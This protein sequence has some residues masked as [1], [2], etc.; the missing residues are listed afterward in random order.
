MTLNHGQRAPIFLVGFMGCG[1]SAVGRELAVLCG[2]SFFDLDDE[3]VR[4]AGQSISDLIGSRGEAEFRQ[5][6][7]VCL[8][9][10]AS[11]QD[12][13]VATGGGV[14]LD[15][16]NRELMHASGVTVWLDAPFGL[17]WERIEIDRTLRPLAPD[18]ETALVRFNDRLQYYQLS[19][20][21][22]AID[23]SMT[24]A[25]IAQFIADRISTP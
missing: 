5:I 10:I 14:V 3:I 4:V 17:C 13:V 6:E 7:S 1:K 19:D 11:N 20:V 9:E 8:R 16:G 25:M 15:A 21:H 22:I 23:D 18:R 24:P 12:A 2:L